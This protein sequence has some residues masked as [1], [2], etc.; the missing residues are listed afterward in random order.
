MSLPRLAAWCARHRRLVLLLW[1]AVL[2]GGVL[3]APALF[4][5]LSGDV[6]HI[7]G[8]ES[9]RAGELLREA[10][11]GGSTIAAVLDG[12]PAGELRPEVDRLATE[13]AALPGV[14][15]VVTP[16]SG[17][18]AGLVATDGEAV[19]VAVT[20]EAGPGGRAAVDDAAALLRDADV[21]RAVV[22]GGP[23]QDDEMDQQAASD[24]AR[25]EIVSMP[26]ALV[27]LV[28]LFGGVVAAGVP[29]LV[30][31]AGVAATLGALLLA[32]AV[33]DVSVYAVNVVTMLGLGLAVDYGLLL[34]SRFRE[35]KAL[36]GDADTA[37]R[38]TFATA[39]RTVAF[40]GF[41][42]AA[43]LSGL[44]VF[45][46]DFLRSMG[47]A[48]L[49]V[50]LLDLVA[51]LTLVPALLAAW[52]RRIRPAP[53]RATGDGFARLARRV[54]RRPVLVLVAVGGVLVL[55]ATPFLG[56][57]FADPDA[58]SLPE[59][60]ASRQLAELAEDRF[61]GAAD[62]DPVTVVLPSPLTAAQTVELAGRL[63]SL[64]GVRDVSVRPDTPGLTVLDVAP[65]G[66]AQGP[67]AMRLVDDVR[68]LGT[69]ALVT[70]DAA[71][72]SDYQ[73][74]LAQ[75]LPW[76]LAVIAVATTVLLF[77]FT[78][79]LV[80]PIKA[81]ALGALSLGASFGALVWVFQDGNLGALVGTEA[82]GSLS[83]TTPVIVLA[84]AFGLSMDYEVF[85]LGRIAEEHRR[86]GDSDLSV[87]RGLQQTGRIVTAAAA[88]IIVV[89]AGF[90]AG[91]FSPIKQ[92]GL[93]LALAVLVDATLVRMLLLPAVMTLMGR[94]NWWA[95]RPLRRLHDRL[96]LT[97]GTPAAVPAPA[98]VPAADAP[99]P[100]P[101]PA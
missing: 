9:A 65:E 74:A 56:V 80:V 2:V 8:S 50:V 21:P 87:E 10:A 82:L 41:T 45:P 68:A 54:R 75:R 46:D 42:V 53:A 15:S 91:G 55:A 26:I 98:P 35:E 62:V 27:L 94:R 57:R 39:G 23:L 38:A 73:D 1:A 43:A 90:V 86:T 71:E 78:G 70:G 72:L 37:L 31:L 32:T 18:D 4:G 97:E 59:S 13:L 24:L 67:V 44:L 76:M 6:G 58:R 96:G 30:A 20:F 60:S 81:L 77:L 28:V 25:A 66:E 3:S 36:T 5:R 47:L 12:R 40:S 64:D 85:L 79:S 95:P 92:I 93:G 29:V 100:V 88:L 33:A 16:W 99:E 51:A 84:I 11:P 69:G 83:I 48:G 49:A 89:F 63:A 17:G 14:A 19:A 7:D 61:P 52:G 22:G 34:V 101:V